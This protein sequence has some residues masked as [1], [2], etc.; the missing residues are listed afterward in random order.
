MKPYKIEFKERISLSLTEENE[1]SVIITGLAVSDKINTRYMK[2]T[3][4]ALDMA[5]IPNNWQG[6]K[7]L[8]DHAYR[9]FDIVG[10]VKN[11]DRVSEGIA[12]GI[13]INP[14]HPSK[15]HIQVKRKDI[16]GV[17]VGGEAE[18]IT[19]SLCNNEVRAVECDHYLGNT[20]EGKTAIG[21]INDFK[22]K[23]LSLT[24]FPADDNA[25]IT[26]FY[27]VAQSINAE[28]KSRIEKDAQDNVVDVAVKI[29][30]DTTEL[31]QKIQESSETFI[32]A[33]NEDKSDLKM[34]DDNP[35]N[36]EITIVEN[37]KIQIL[38]SALD[39]FSKENAELSQYVTQK[40]AEEKESK[41]AKIMELSDMAKEKLDSFSDESLDA[42]LLTLSKVKQPK[43][44]NKPKGSYTRVP[45][46]SL[47]QADA[48][49]KK[50]LV[51][52][53]FGFDNP[54]E[55]AVK[56]VE[57]MRKRPNYMI[58]EI[59]IGEKGEE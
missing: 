27:G 25:K 40:K 44:D 45:M 49:S 13:D 52:Q 46:I 29:D 2:F 34:T 48:K 7:T 4:K 9:S 10:Q 22:L 15:V 36:E 32:N 33:K 54:S 17:S 3:D 30:I 51:R 6:A 19:C 55:S 38:E 14:H 12:F 11:F 42:T 23:E 43:V 31:E 50:E 16:D 26:G 5:S 41:I 47:E 35:N 58:G 21:L 37:E 39:K 20:Y 53:L 18:S 8:V 1:D 28:K 57:Q 56:K 59:V 24:G